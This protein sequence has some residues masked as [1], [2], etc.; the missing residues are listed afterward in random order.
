MTEKKVASFITCVTASFAGDGWCEWNLEVAS[1][2]PP[3]TLN[4]C[5]LYYELLVG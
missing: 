2:T 5:K 3:T 1:A 4:G